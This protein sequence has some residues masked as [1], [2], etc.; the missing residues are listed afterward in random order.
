[1]SFHLACLLEIEVVAVRCEYSNPQRV[2]SE[3]LWLSNLLCQDSKCIRK[4]FDCYSDFSDIRFL[5]WSSL[6]VVTTL[7]LK[8]MQ[9]SFS[10][11]K[12]TWI[13][14]PQIAI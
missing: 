10:H 14:L 1:M 5:D 4:P 9:S 6:N 2:T 11:C 12:A 7:V 8:N 3:S 13:H